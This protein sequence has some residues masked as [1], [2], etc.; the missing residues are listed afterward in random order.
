MT[1]HL[2]S[3]ARTL[4]G[5]IEGGND[6]LP[7]EG[8]AL[9]LFRLQF[10]ANPTYARLCR[11]QRAT[12]DF[13]TDWR[14]IPAVPTAAFKEL[15]ITSLDPSRRT[16]VFQSS[17]TTGQQRSRH[18][19]CPESL[20]LYEAAAWHWFRMHL[21]SAPNDGAAADPLL[22]VSLTPPPEQVPLSSLVHM[23]ASVARRSLASEVLFH[24]VVG[25]D[26]RW[27]VRMDDLRSLLK[28]EVVAKRPILLLGTAFNMV[29]LV[30]GMELR[31]ERFELCPGSRIMETG[32]YKGQ[33]REV[34]KDE[35]YHRLS[36]VL[37]VGIDRIVCEY[38]MSEL[39]SQAYDHP[40]HQP[41]PGPSE[42][43][44]HFPPWVGTVVIDPE[45]GR[46][47][48]LEE[49][50]LLRICD[51]ANVWSVMAIQTEDRVRRRENG[52]ELLGRFATAEPRGCS[53]M[54]R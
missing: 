52:F 2:E 22:W 7:F 23:I 21:L 48:G 27:E 29:H 1:H 3:F 50:G 25:P 47:A 49:V 37:G 9:E 38:G 10:E 16:A 14:Q 43:R 6:V 15:E 44:M 30:E 26:D 31:N 54:A 24:G 34:A 35:L 20:E 40:W 12:P 42:R 28:S 46:E 51:L 5:H 4:L 19:H 45:T 33:S 53:L 13:V 17:G 11:A 39:S 32:G 8:L 18:F 36:A 41:A